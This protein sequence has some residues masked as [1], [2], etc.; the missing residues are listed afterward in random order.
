MDLSNLSV[1]DLQH[2]QKRDFESMSP[3]GLQ[4][5]QKQRAQER[6][7]AN[8]PQIPDSADKAAQGSSPNAQP[9]SFIQALE[10]RSKRINGVGWPELP[11]AGRS[12]ELIFEKERKYFFL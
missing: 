9:L 11:P 10:N 6:L 3:Q 8:P 4:E 5:L 12:V 7:A 1:E 2:L